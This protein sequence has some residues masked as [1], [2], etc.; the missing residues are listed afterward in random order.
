MKS[1]IIQLTV[2]LIFFQLT[3][4]FGHHLSGVQYVSPMPDARNVSQHTSIIVRFDSIAPNDIINLSS[5]IQVTDQAGRQVPGDIKIASD[6]KTIVFKPHA[7]LVPG[8]HMSVS[9]SPQTASSSESRENSY[10]FSVSEYEEIPS[11]AEGIEINNLEKASEPVVPGPWYK[12]KANAA[13]S[14][15]KSS[16]SSSAVSVPSDFPHVAITMSDNPDTGY[17]FMNSW[18]DGPAYNIIFDNSGAPIWYHK[19]PDRR[20]DFKVQKNGLITM[21][22][23]SGY[24]F[25]QGFIAMDHTYTEV[26]SFHAV[27]GYQTD[28]HELQVLEDGHYLLIGIRQT[29]VDMR[30]YVEG[31]SRN[32]SVLESIIQEFTPEHDLIFQWRAWDHF[33]IA[34][35]YVP[36]ENEL[37]SSSI[38][39][40]HMNA[41]DIDT[42]GH[43]LLSSRHLSEITKIN[44]QTGEI[45]WRLGGEKNQFTF[46]NDPLN[47][48]ENQHDVRVVGEN[49]FTVFDNGNEH[50]PPVSRAT[51]Y[52][53]DPDSMKA[54]LVWEFR[55]NP[56]KYSYWMGNHQRLP[57][58]NRLINWAD[59][60]LP[61]ITEVRENGEIAFELW[62]QNYIH[63]YRVFRFPWQG[64]AQEPY[65]VVESHRESVNLIFN[66]FGDPDVAYYNIYGGQSPNPTTI[67]DS[68]TTTQAALTELENEA[69]YYFRV[70]AVDSTGRESPFSNEVSALANFIKPGQNM[71]LNGDFSDRKRHWFFWAGDGATANWAVEDGICHIQIQNGS[72]EDYKVQFVQFEMELLEGEEYIFEFDAWAD[73]Q[74]LMSAFILKYGGDYDNYSQ[75]SYMLLKKQRQHYEFPFTMTYPSDFTAI[76]VF[77]FGGSDHDVYLDDITVRRVV[78]SQVESK[79]EAIP[80]QYDLIGNFPNPFN[81]GTTIQFSVP[82]QTMVRLDLY[83]I[84]GQF[85]KTISDNVY[86][87][88]VHRVHFDAHD[89]GSGVYFCKMT[90]SANDY[91]DVHKLI[92]MK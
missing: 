47:G 50:N 77:A 65:L 64:K 35:T 82:E 89:L 17:I 14:L 28:E 42:D 70:T 32:A 51:E 11:I 59:G 8:A 76:L 16:I 49:R 69:R 83:N 2:I 13:K 5:C 24:P 62:W 33:D 1:S 54:T 18:W 10:H 78:E 53:V 86:D 74:R 84:L 7:P 81:A 52:L 38:R 58:G 63:T 68:S 60:S 79:T 41:I 39:F 87:S 56:D 92:L 12:S 66:K 40:P 30:Q 25:G 20:R 45:M 43:I 91:V 80:L 37:T 72:D 48:P 19:Y 61:K 88:G 85:E 6:H 3:T 75:T 71:V 90:T 9:L 26:D 55:D 4:V 57:N 31:G 22:V 15:L 29:Q 67:I 36:I 34:D 27:N 21:L 73:E 23:R 44:R 46:I